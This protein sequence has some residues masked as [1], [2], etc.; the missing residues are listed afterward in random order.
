M[1]KMKQLLAVVAFA[2]AFSFVFMSTQDV[3][4][5][6]SKR[7]AGVVYV[8]PQTDGY[9]DLV[10]KNF[11]KMRIDQNGS[12]SFKVY[13]GREGDYISDVK[14]NKKGLIAGV[15]YQYNSYYPT[16]AA[17]LDEWDAYGRIS[18]TAFKEGTYNVSFKVC[19]ADGSVAGSYKVKVYAGKNVVVKQ[20]KLGSKVVLNNVTKR[21]GTTFTTTTNTSYQVANS[22]KSAKLKLT[23]NKGYK[24]TGF[25]Y[26][27]TNAD[28][29]PMAK[30]VKN[31]KAIKL[32]QQ[33]AERNYY[34]DGESWINILE[35]M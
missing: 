25:V 24:I 3:E 6:V 27:Y 10:W 18:L 1:K 9:G 30:A 4:A 15:T 5:A 13:F 34:A 21:K 29:K 19:K 14:V 23:A 7:Q 16:D 12:T 33:Y 2:L 11:T 31:G 17:N 35:H 22:L 28:G 26:V 32:S 8:N 20:A